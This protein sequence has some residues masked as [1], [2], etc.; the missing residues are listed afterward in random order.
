MY[1]TLTLLKKYLLYLLKAENG[2]GHGV[3]SPFVFSFI[4]EVLNYQQITP[5]ANKIE[6]QRKSLEG[7]AQKIQVWDRGAGS[8]QTNQTERSVRQIAKAALKSKKYGQLLYKIVAYYKPAQILEMGTSLGIT[9]CYLAAGNINASL[10]T[11]EGAPNV[12]TI[13][14]ETF[15][16]VGFQHIELME[17][18][19]NNTLPV[20]LN[21]LE[22]VGLAYIDGNHRHEPTMQYFKSLLEKSKE[23]TVLIFDDIHWSDEME[24]AWNEIKL[25]P[26]VT[27]TIDLFFIGLVFVRK[28]Q[29]EKEHFIIRY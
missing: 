22:E 2:R 24:K 12:A 9:T 19:F 7:N 15:K 27:L 5:L 21:S 14:K 13:A 23:D 26:S 6:D 1:S 25:H 4:K 10:V 28:A 29:K 11:L 3:H 20:Y 16:A 18:D 8:R 17:G